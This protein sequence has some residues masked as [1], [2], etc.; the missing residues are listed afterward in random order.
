MELIEGPMLT[1]IIAAAVTVSAVGLYFFV[2]TAP[3]RTTTTTLLPGQRPTTTTLF[4][5]PTS[6]TSSTSSTSPTTS[7]STTLMEAENLTS[8]YDINL[9]AATVVKTLHRCEDNTTFGKCSKSKPLYCSDGELVSNCSYCGC[10][11][12]EECQEDG[13]CAVVIRGWGVDC[14][15]WDLYP[16]TGIDGTKCNLELAA[17]LGVK[18]VRAGMWEDRGKSSGY[19]DLSGYDGYIIEA[20]YYGMEV[21]ANL[22]TYC[23]WST[24][25]EW[26]DNWFPFVEMIVERYKGNIAVYEILNE[27]DDPNCNECIETCGQQA[28]TIWPTK[29]GFDENISDYVDILN[30]TYA[31]IKSI[32]PNATVIMGGTTNQDDGS[33]IE[34]MIDDY[35]ALTDGIVTHHY[36]DLYSIDNVLLPKIARMQDLDMPMWIT[37]MGQDDSQ[38]VSYQVDWIR[39]MFVYLNGTVD[40]VVWFTYPYLTDDNYAPT[41]AYY[42]YQNCLT[43]G[44]CE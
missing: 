10:A 26:D 41:A 30:R 28:S 36:G 39:K 19:W 25:A 43:G 32:D 22:L 1:I 38:G 6:P 18:W 8:H 37:E 35:G 29:M 14:T 23:G 16:G 13:S 5:T 3:E 31:L 24:M 12:E 27:Q 42:A 20:R 2:S 34:T 11:G 4:P 17:D 33:Y 7:T 44:V 15:H 9:T 21:I 40:N